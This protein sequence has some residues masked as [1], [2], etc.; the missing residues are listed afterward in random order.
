LLV[1]S[2]VRLW[3]E[4]EP[5]EG[6]NG[7]GRRRRHRGKWRSDS[8][9][10]RTCRMQAREGAI[11]DSQELILAVAGKNVGLAPILPSVASPHPCTP[12]RAIEALLVHPDTSQPTSRLVGGAWGQRPQVGVYSDASVLHCWKFSTSKENPEQRST[13]RSP[14]SHQFVPD[15][16]VKVNYPGVDFFK[17]RL[18]V[19]RV[20]GA[21]SSASPHPAAE[22][23]FSN[24][25]LQESKFPKESRAPKCFGRRHVLKLSLNHKT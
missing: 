7:S 25:T 14:R 16:V 17:K 4:L 12:T 1:S 6:P 2:S 3:W 21:E 15:K 22:L 20:G 9:R 13:P 24:R 10:S 19:I 8:R 23:D 18:V 11:P 5:P